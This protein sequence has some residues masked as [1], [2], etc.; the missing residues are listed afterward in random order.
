MLYQRKDFLPQKGLTLMSLMMALA[1]TGILSALSVPGFVD[2]LN[3]HERQQARSQLLR[4]QAE[5]IRF[6]LANAGY[7]GKVAL[8]APVIKKY[9]FTVIN[10]SAGGYVLRAD[11]IKGLNDGCDTLTLDAAGTYAPVKCWH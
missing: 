2:L 9:T 11:R 10:V 7:A 1:V 4:W 3:R 5:Q 6:R 8:S